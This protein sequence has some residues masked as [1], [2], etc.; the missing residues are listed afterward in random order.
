M[1]T[2]TNRILPV[3]AALVVIGL[4]DLLT[5]LVW[6]HT[7]HA[8]EI[9]PIMA[10]VLRAGVGVFVALKLFTLAAYVAVMEWY[11]RRRSA[12]FA[13]LVGRITLFSYAAI[14]ALSF[15]CVNSGLVLG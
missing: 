4:I 1:D 13:Y 12:S 8:I 7:G 3:N 2:R 15:A 10:A 11:R 5:T 6:L 14:Y 9:N